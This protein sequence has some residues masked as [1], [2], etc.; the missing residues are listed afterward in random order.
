MVKGWQTPPEIVYRHKGQ[1]VY[2]SQRTEDYT[3]GIQAFRDKRPP[4]FRGR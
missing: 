4:R 1:A 2:H 3:E